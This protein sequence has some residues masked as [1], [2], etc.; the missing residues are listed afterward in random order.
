MPQVTDS[1]VFWTHKGGVGKTTLCMHTALTYAEL[2]PKQHVIVIDLDEQ[3][4]LSS[5]L[6]TE[7]GNVF[8]S[9]ARQPKNGLEQVTAMQGTFVDNSGAYSRT[10]CGMLLAGE[11]N[12]YYRCKHSANS[13]QQQI[14]ESAFLINPKKEGI[15]DNLPENVHLLC[16]DRRIAGLSA[17]FVQKCAHPDALEAQ[18]MGSIEAEWKTTHL[19][20]KDWVTAVATELPSNGFDGVTVFIDCNPSMNFFTELGMCTAKKLVVPVNA[21]DFSLA[22]VKNMFYSIYGMYQVGGNMAAYEKKMFHSVAKGDATKVELPKVHAIIHNRSSMWGKKQATCFAAM[23]KEQANV[24]Y[25]AYDDARKGEGGVPPGSHRNIFNHAQLHGG[26]EPSTAEEFADAFT[27]VMR[28]MGS[29]AVVTVHSGIGLWLV[30]RNKKNVKSIL[31]DAKVSSSA[32]SSLADLIGPARQ[33]LRADPEDEDNPGDHRNGRDLYL[34]ELL[35]G[36][37]VGDE[38]REN[39]WREASQGANELGWTNKRR[40]QAVEDDDVAP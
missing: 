5:T 2:N 18:G 34:V 28:D 27:G 4:N 38:V 31:P 8:E 14:G 15:N 25:K 23:S 22:A 36:R 10:L 35:Q 30:K 7:L 3:A 1:Y 40:R 9:H 32:A 17:H 11:K 26:A 20:L 6:C 12:M 21:D 37:Q 33:S 19:L 29:T 24:M 16:G 13:M 39:I